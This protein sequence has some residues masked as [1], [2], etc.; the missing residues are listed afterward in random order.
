MM[1]KAL[2]G[3]ESSN[4][5]VGGRYGQQRDPRAFRN[6][7][8]DA[9]AHG[10][11][12]EK[13]AALVDLAE[14]GTGLPEEILEQSNFESLAKFYFIFIRFNFIWTLN[15]FALIVLNFLEK[16][17]WCSEGSAYPCNDRE[18]YYL[19]ELPY[20]TGAESLMYE[21][22]TLMI[23]AIHILFPILFE[24]FSIY[25]RSILNKSKVFVSGVIFLLILAAD[26]LVYIL[27]LSPVAFYSLPLRIAPYMRVVFFILNIRFKVNFEFTP[28]LWWTNNIMVLSCLFLEFPYV[29][30]LK[31]E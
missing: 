4:G 29:E 18:Y 24:G 22:I 7:R 10:S 13:A 19:G 26:I 2:L 6:S 25:W 23:L 31:L 8:L 16:P 27:Y 15:Y 9:I 11:S 1:E 30:V 17:L 20:L 12:Y 5:G 28:S 14:D 21:G 3:G